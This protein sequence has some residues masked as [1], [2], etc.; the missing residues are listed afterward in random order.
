MLGN[1]IIGPF[2]WR[3]NRIFNDVSR[4]TEAIADNNLTQNV[5]FLNK[6]ELQHIMQHPSFRKF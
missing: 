3:G 5:F 1:N 2:S 6:T 4:I